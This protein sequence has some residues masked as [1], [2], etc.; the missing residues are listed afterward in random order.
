MRRYPQK[1]LLITPR[2]LSTLRGFQIIHQTF[3]EWYTDEQ[4]LHFMK[5]LGYENRTLYDIPEDVAYILKKM[6]ELTLEDSFKILKDSIIYFKDDENIPH[7]QYE[8][9][10]EIG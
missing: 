10:E 5:K 8:G 3:L 2:V 6:P 9:V 7:D 4:I 1:V